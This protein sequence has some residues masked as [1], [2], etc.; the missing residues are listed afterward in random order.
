NDQ[1]AEKLEAMDVLSD[2]SAE[3]VRQLMTFAR[4]DIVQ[5]AP[6][7]LNALLHN[8][9]RLSKSIVPENIEIEMALCSDEL[10]VHG[11]AAQLQQVLLNLINNAC[12]A[13]ADRAKPRISLTLEYVKT[14]KALRKKHPILVTDQLAHITLADNGYGMDEEQLAQIFDPFYT[15]KEVGKGTGLGMSMVYGAVQTHKGAIEIES[16]AGKGT[17]V[18]LYLPLEERVEAMEQTAEAAAEFETAAVGTTVLLVDDNPGI[19]NVCSETLRSCGH[20][21]LSAGNG[22]EALELFKANSESIGLVITDILM[23]KMDGFE[24]AEHIRIIKPEMQIIFMTGYD[25]QHADI[26]EPLKRNGT[27][28]TKPFSM[29]EL[30]QKM[31]FLMAANRKE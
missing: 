28:V 11:D 15:T 4:K 5:K 8:H 6:L 20:E 2:H 12:D 21:V 29:D 1:V 23:P 17:S 9:K 3:M 7:S 26:P 30:L 16:K 19:R 10:W 25:P 18:H 27:I 13:V 22:V 31:E 14:G 24:L